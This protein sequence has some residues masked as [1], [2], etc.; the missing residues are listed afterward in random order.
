MTEPF[1]HEKLIVYQ[2]GMRFAAFRGA[3]LE[4]MPRRVAAC[5]HLDRGAESILNRTLNRLP[6]SDTLNRLA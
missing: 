4:R 5:D 2:K 6:Y 1:G 3:L